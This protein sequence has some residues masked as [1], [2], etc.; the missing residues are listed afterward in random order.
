MDSYIILNK[1][2]PTLK[3]VTLLSVD[4]YTPSVEE[5]VEIFGVESY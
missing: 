5:M 1:L 3:G 2:L 4:T